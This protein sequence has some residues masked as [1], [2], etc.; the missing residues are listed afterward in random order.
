MNPTRRGPW[1]LLLLVLAG[2]CGA[3][4]L[5]AWVTATAT[6]PVIGTVDVR[7]TGAAAAPG[8][9]GAS[10]VLAAAAIALGLVGR[11]GRWV[12]CVVVAAAGA[13]VVVGALGAR[14]GAVDRAQQR[15]ADLTG[16]GVLD[17]DVTL[18][19]WPWA[20][21]GLGVLVVIAAIL[22]LRASAHWAAPSSRH[23]RADQQPVTRRSEPPEDDE[24]ATWDAL[25]RGDDPT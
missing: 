11:I 4:T 3:V 21:V 10:L 15:A 24:R 18:A 9:I 6:G 2:L 14:A 1:V 20:A 16:V 13:L 8:V 17:G 22:L 5:P 25:G 7:V 23:E 19:P 12:V